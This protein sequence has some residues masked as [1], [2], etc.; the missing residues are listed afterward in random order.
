MTAME[1]LM[2]DAADALI[3]QLELVELKKE[4]A[5]EEDKL[6]LI[7]YGVYAVE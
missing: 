4:Y 5:Q 2:M 6:V 7:M 3:E 1:A